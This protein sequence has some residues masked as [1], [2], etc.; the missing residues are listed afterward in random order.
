MPVGENVL[1]KV[2]WPIRKT[3]TIIYWTVPNKRIYKIKGV[4]ECRSAVSLRTSDQSVRNVRVFVYTFDGFSIRINKLYLHL[5]YMF[6]L[7]TNTYIYIHLYIYIY[8]IFSALCKYV[9]WTMWIA[10][11]PLLVVEVLDQF[12]GPWA[13]VVVS[14][15]PIALRLQTM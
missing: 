3:N 11:A 13:H 10:V 15:Y 1:E 8:V 7:P 9:G 6:R 2:M 4:L 5:L 14:L 12:H